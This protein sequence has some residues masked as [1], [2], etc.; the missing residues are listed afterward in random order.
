LKEKIPGR[1]E[2][3]KALELNAPD[4]SFPLLPLLISKVRETGSDNKAVAAAVTPDLLRQARRS[5]QKYDVVCNWR[6]AVHISGSCQSAQSEKGSVPWFSPLLAHAVE[7]LFQTGQSPASVDHNS[8]R[9]PV[10]QSTGTNSAS[11]FVISFQICR[12]EGGGG[13]RGAND[14][15]GKAENRFL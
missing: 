12:G 7:S 3:A 1:A 10:V 14:G 8:P 4:A 15:E 11:F 6:C 13:R 5:F 9:M 2:L